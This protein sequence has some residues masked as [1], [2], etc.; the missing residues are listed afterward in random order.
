[1][2]T[3]TVNGKVT[4]QDL[5]TGCWGIIDDKGREW[6]AVNMPEQLKQPGKQV[7]VSIKEVDEGASIFMWGTPVKIVSFST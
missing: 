6:R 5:G 4:Y 7:T 1:M 2:K 3:K